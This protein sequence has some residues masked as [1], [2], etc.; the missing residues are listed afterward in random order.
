MGR[1]TVYNQIYSEEL[2]AQ[3][4]DD[5]KMLLQDFIDYKKAS[6][7]S[8]AT[9][10]QYEQMI[11]LFLCWNQKYNKGTFFVDLKKRQIIKFFTYMVSDMNC[12]SNRIATVKSALSS[13]SNY[14]ED[15][16]DDEYEDFKNLIVKI[17]TPVK[18]PVRDKTILE[19]PQINECLEKL[20]AAEKYQIACYMALAAA[21]GA[22]KAE[23][24]RFKVDYFKDENIVFGCLYK[25]PEPIKTKGR[26]SKGKMLHKYTFVKQ[27]KPYF[28][29]WM[30]YRKEHG[31]D[32]E[33]LFVVKDGTGYKQAQVSSADNWCETITKFLGIPFYSHS[34]RHFYVTQM[35]RQNL[36]DN[37]VT[38]LVGWEK[39]NGG[40]MC[41]IYSDIDVSDTLGDYFDEGG[42]K[43]DIKVGTISDM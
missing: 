2:W 11:R 36:P 29:K 34:M 43:Q 9:L 15:I 13:M 16:L 27:F 21:S 30:A 38:A 39:G 31:I 28:D 3:V 40:A 32:S 17:E 1:S 37:V 19:E 33:W 8:P 41:A 26:T 5:N 7:K 20:V 14:I 12:S 24:L 10:Y 25:T 35:K 22:R 6:D 23:L 4:S 18:Q 42:I